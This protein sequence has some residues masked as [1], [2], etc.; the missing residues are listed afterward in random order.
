MR[1]GKYAS[2]CYQSSVSAV[3]TALDKVRHLDE[4]AALRLLAWIDTHTASKVTNARPKG[5][6]AMLGF[7]RKFHPKPQTTADWIKELRAG[8][9]I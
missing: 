2:M 8:D 1:L 7:A 5:A 4:P 6:M 3:E 9:D